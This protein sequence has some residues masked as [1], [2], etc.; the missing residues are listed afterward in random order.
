MAYV[1]GS[2]YD[3][4]VSYASA[5]NVRSRQCP[6]GWVTDFVRSL[7]V[8]LLQRLG[9][10]NDLAIYIDQRELSS[11]DE[12]NELLRAVEASAVFLSICS[13]SYVQRKWTVKELDHFERSIGDSKR[14]FA[15]EILP[16]GAGETYPP[17]LASRRRLPFYKRSSALAKVSV[18][19]EP[20][21]SE[22]GM[23]IHDLAEQLRYQLL[24]LRAVTDVRE[25]TR[26]IRQATGGLEGGR[27]V[28]AR[29]DPVDARTLRRA[30]PAP[31]LRKMRNRLREVAEVSRSFGANLGW[32]VKTKRGYE[33]LSQKDLAIKA[34]NDVLY[35]ARISDLE[36]G[37]I[38]NPQQKTVDALV[39]ALNITPGEL[40]K[41]REESRAYNA[42]ERR[43][44]QAVAAASAAAM[45][46]SSAT[47]TTEL[48]IA[49]ET[50]PAASHAESAE[51]ASTVPPWETPA[52]TSA[53]ATLS[54]PATGTFEVGAASEAT[55]TASHVAAL[56]L[57]AN[58]SPLVA[59]A[60][61]EVPTR[62]RRTDTW[63]LVLAAIGVILS[64]L[65]L[66]IGRGDVFSNSVSATGNIEGSTITISGPARPTER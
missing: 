55:P 27:V 64:A 19:L 1:P 60:P 11:N 42:V 7:E 63:R 35:K 46:Q 13:R 2:T 33:G 65:A 50:W 9:G 51:P 16:L 61:L 5:D 54:S 12:L 39:V 29:A 43:S 25:A 44:S 57:L 52:E 24:A 10:P 23:L 15:V 31:R 4:F 56:Q 59:P 8:A 58:A 53:G 28:T 49:F 48:G 62:W 3:V 26:E 66:T 47:E 38:A 32:L 41:C 36:N 37:K 6:E 20:Q 34:F 30:V 22:Y 14:L 18:P 17:Q 40:E 45:P 21:D